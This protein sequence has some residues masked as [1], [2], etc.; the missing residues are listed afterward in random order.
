MRGVDFREIEAELLAGALVLSRQGRACLSAPSAIGPRPAY[1]PKSR[2]A[3]I[4][5]GKQ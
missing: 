5:E 2:C 3:A 1:T 4:I